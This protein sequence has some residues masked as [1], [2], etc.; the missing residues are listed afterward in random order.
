MGVCQ[1]AM[2]E[3]EAQFKDPALE[4]E[5]ND[6]VRRRENKRTG[7]IEEYEAGDN[8]QDND[9]F[10]F[11]EEEV[12]EGEEFM[13]VKPWIGAV[14]EP[15][16][17]PE[18][19]PSPPDVCYQ[20]EYAYGYRCQDSRQNIYYSCNDEICYMTACL[21]VI[22]NKDSNTQKFFGGGEVENSSKQVS[23]T[24]DSHN[25]DIMCMDVN[26]SGGRNL[27]VTGQV[28]KWP[29]VFIWDTTTGEKVQRFQLD[30]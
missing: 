21:G 18:P 25:N 5:M 30:K 23:S 20:L 10:L 17:H 15:D 12:K 29:A 8:D 7:E 19:N 14:K 4:E 26:T 1:S 28:G 9:A 2:D 22:L 11:E 24:K 27:A 3:V 6:G 16:N 13:A